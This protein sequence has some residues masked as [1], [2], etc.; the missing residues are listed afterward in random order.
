MKRILFL[1][2]L[3]SLSCATLVAQDFP[4]L[5]DMDESGVPN[6]LSSSH[7]SGDSTKAHKEVPKGMYVWTVDE[8][9]GDRT[10]VDRDTINYLFMKTVL[11]SGKYGQYNTTGNLGAP[12]INRI[13]IDRPA[14]LKYM[15][16]SPLDF[17]YTPVDQ[18]RY[19]NTLSPITNLTFNTCGDRM[20]GEDHLNVKFAA[21]AGKEFGFGMKFDYIYGRGYYQNQSTALFDWTFW[22][23]YLG[24]RYQ[25]HFLFSTDHVKLTENGGIVNDDYIHHPESFPSNFQLSE[26]PTRLSENWNRINSLHFFL[27]HRYCVGFNRKVPMTEE[28]IKAKRFAIQSQKEKEKQELKEKSREKNNNTVDARLTGRPADAIIAGDLPDPKGNDDVSDRIAVNDSTIMDS[29]IAKNTV[30]A[31]DTSWLK[32]EYVP[33]TSFIHTLKLDSYDR[34]YLA[35]RSPKD[36]YANKFAIPGDVQGDSIKDQTKYLML[37]NTFAVGLLEGFNKWAKAGMKVFIA[38]QL[39]HYQLADKELGSKTFNEMTVSVGAQ[40][41][42]AQGR[43]FH[44][45]ATGELGI[46]GE[47]L[48]DMK[49]DAI[50]DVVIPLFGDSTKVKLNAF[51][52]REK[53]EYYMRHYHSKHFWWD[54]DFSKQTHSHLEGSVTINKTRTALRVAYDNI[55]NYTYMAMSY[56][57]PEGQD[58]ITNYQVNARQTS[59]N[60]SLLTAELTQNF[61]LGILNWENRIT[62]QKSTEQS[63]LPVPTLNVWTNLYLNFRIAKVLRVHFGADATYF[64]EYEAPEYASQLASFAVQENDAVKQKVGNYPFVNVYANFLLKGCRFFAMMSHVNAGQ[65]NK[66][67]FTTPHHPMNERIFRLGLSWY[68]NN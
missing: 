4:S 45:N 25:A 21:N 48:G 24:E 46:A 39:D 59:S 34:T 33:V 61:R 44:Y 20:D 2:I 18:L 68:F 38:H 56:N 29:L 23:S 27:T 22:A 57:R 42:K 15:F 11:T 26:I 1:L 31:E 51:M 8:R 40:L 58:L 32:N 66:N 64:T 43:Y 30:Q 47:R 52:H 5:S 16:T 67:Y 6:P 7:S 55:D 14:S 53:P 54:N 36:Y 37:R 28:E 62:W 3:F 41:I 9:F 63:I 60:I 13:F 19:T 10:A 35:Y 50:G 49:I 17:F 65:G 12:R